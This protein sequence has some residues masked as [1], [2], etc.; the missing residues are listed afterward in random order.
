MGLLQEV[1]SNYQCV[2]CGHIHHVQADN[3]I[4]L[5]DDLYYATYCP[6]CRDVV[7]HLWVGDNEVDKYMYMD[8]DLDQR[9][10]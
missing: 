8:I 2:N 4:D 6:E 10:Y 1:Q 3:V 7:K 5:G 9:Y